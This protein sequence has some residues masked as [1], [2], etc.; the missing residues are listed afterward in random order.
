MTP[1]FSEPNWLHVSRVSP[2]VSSLLSPASSLHPRDPP[3]PPLRSPWQAPRRA[4]W[5]SQVPPPSVVQGARWET[6][7][8]C[9]L[10]VV[11]RLHTLSL[12][13]HTHTHTNTPSPAVPSSLAL[14]SSRRYLL[15]LSLY[16]GVLLRIQ[17]ETGMALLLFVHSL[18]PR[19]VSLKEGAVCSVYEQYEH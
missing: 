11:R 17:P 16:P 10:Q 18:K 2:T 3:P 15:P 14:A 12:S 13:T 1:A 9:R 19:S 4:I 5:A 7:S 8:S 6:I